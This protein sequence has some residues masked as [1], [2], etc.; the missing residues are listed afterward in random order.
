MDYDVSRIEGTVSRNDIILWKG[1]IE[2]LLKLNSTN[3]EV[4]IGIDISCMSKENV[5]PLKEGGDIEEKWRRDKEERKRWRSEFKSIYRKLINKS[6]KYLLGMRD[7]VVKETIDE[8]S[9]REGRHIIYGVNREEEVRGME[10][11]EYHNHN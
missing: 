7:E 8:R 4:I 9:E 5:I 6:S 10:R 2:D 11:Y 3:V 1:T